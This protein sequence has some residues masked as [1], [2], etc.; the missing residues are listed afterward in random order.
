MKCSGNVRVSNFNFSSSYWW[1][2]NMYSEIDYNNDKHVV[3]YFLA[4]LTWRV[5]R[6]IAIIWSPS[7]SWSVNIYILIFFPETT[8]TIGT[9]LNLVWMFIGWSLHSLCFCCWSE[10]HKRNKRSKGC[11]HIYGYKLLFIWFFKIKEFINVFLNKILFI[12]M[13]NIIM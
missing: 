6:V 7:L 9:K 3:Y 8:W 1:Q 4:H 5:M 11:V 10:V 12:D 13:H 2:N